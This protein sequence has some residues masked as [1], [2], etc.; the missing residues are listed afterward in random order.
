MRKGKYTSKDGNIEEGVWN[1]G[2]Q[3]LKIFRVNN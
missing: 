2:K 1:N 3:T